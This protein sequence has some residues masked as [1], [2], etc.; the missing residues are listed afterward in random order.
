[1]TTSVKIQ[2]IDTSHREIVVKVGGRPDF[3]LAPGEET[4]EVV[5]PGQDVSISEGVIDAAAD[6]AHNATE[7]AKAAEKAEGE[8]REGDPA[9][10]ETKT[11]EA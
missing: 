1:M 5:Y 2:N 4:T 6:D 11:E 7:A 9:P 10:A 3:V 8:K